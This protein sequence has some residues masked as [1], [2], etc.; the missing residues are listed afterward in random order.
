M[1]DLN[2]II[3]GI[4]LFF[5]VRLVLKTIGFSVYI[6]LGFVALYFILEGSLFVKAQEVILT[7]I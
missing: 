6:A 1:F 7:S 4:S 2:T 3:I 5:I